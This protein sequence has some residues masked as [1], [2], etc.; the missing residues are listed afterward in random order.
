MV[1][2]VAGDSK[3]ETEVQNL[4]DILTNA[5]AGFHSNLLIKEEGG[6]LSIHTKEPMDNGK[7][8][9]RLPRTVLMPGDQYNLDV[10]GNDF[11]ITYSED[12][13]ATDLQKRIIDKMYE[14][15]NLT[16]K[17]KLHEEFSFLL[18]LK[19]SPALLDKL[20][21]GRDFALGPYADWLKWVKA[22]MSEEQRRSVICGTYIK[23]RPLGYS[24]PVRESSV[25]MIMPVLDFMNHHWEGGTFSV[26]ELGVRKGDLT[27][28]SCQPFPDSKEC[29]AN[30]GVLDPFDSLLRYDFIDRFSP[31]LRSVAVD[32]EGPAGDVIHV[33]NQM[34]FVYK[35]DL[36]KELV[37]LRRYIPDIAVKDDQVTVSHL[38]LPV[39][40][41][42]FALVR[43]LNQ[44]LTAYNKHHSKVMDEKEAKEWRRKAQE[45]V[46]EKNRTYYEE[47]L[48]VTNDLTKDKK[49]SFGVLR[50]RE[51]AEHQLNAL[52]SYIIQE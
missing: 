41:S 6:G 11:V 26:N 40:K 8:I 47:L 22:G 9:I 27:M 45:A 30:Y 20:N 21:E 36:Q 38:I 52:R 10:S 50:V 48:V 43:V 15:Y 17:V 28:H 4:L 23:T 18:S 37:D 42:K 16:N 33:K 44:I 24:D 34:N 14:I 29:Y 3:I 12:S 31:I 1:T 5:G 51:L 2:I 25:S 35:K 13:I 39:D 46:V 19:N 49:D 7:E 32:L